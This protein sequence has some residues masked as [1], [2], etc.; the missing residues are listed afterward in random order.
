MKSVA[1]TAFK[2]LGG[3]LLLTGLIAGLKVLVIGWATIIVV[4]LTVLLFVFGLLSFSRFL[5]KRT[6]ALFLRPLLCRACS[7]TSRP[8]KLGR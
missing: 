2:V 5:Q 3:I 4:V 8:F 7:L 6:T 1:K